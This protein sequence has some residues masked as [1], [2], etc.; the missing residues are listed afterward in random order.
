MQKTRKPLSPAR[1]VSRVIIW[2][3][4]AVVL[5]MRVVVL[6]P[7]FQWERRGASPSWHQRQPRFRRAPTVMHPPMSEVPKD[8]LRIQ[9]EIA[10]PDA[11]R[12]RR[13]FWDG[14]QGRRQERPEVRAT[15]REGGAVY[16]NVAVHLKGAAGSFRPF[17]DKPALTLSFAKYARGQRFHGYAKLSLNNSVQD[18]TYLCEAISRELFE[19]AGVPVPRV[20]FAT[21][22]INGVDKGLYV[23]AEGYNKDF[24][25]R[26]YRNVNGNLYDGG[27]CREVNPNLEVN[28]GDHPDDRS[29]LRRLLAAAS[30]PAAATRWNRLT[31]VLDTDRFITFLAM[32]V[33]LCH[34]DGYALNR[35]NYRLFHDLET[36]RLIFMPHGLDQMFDWPPG[37]F[38]PEGPILP[39]M[40]G[41]VAWAVMSTPQGGRQYL[42]RLGTLRTNVLQE[43]VVTQRV[44]ELA[45]RIRPTL[46]AYDPEAARRHDAAVASL[47]ERITR[48][49]RSVSEQLSA[50]REPMKF[51]AS[52]TA[53]LTHWTPHVSPPRAPLTLE[54]VEEHGRRL[55]H[56][57]AGNAGGT[58]SWRSRVNLEGGQYRFEGRA[59][60]SGGSRI[61]LRISG[62]RLPPQAVAGTD[63]VP[64]SYTLNV[65]GFM[66]EVE[67]IC[68]FSGTRGEAW[69][70]LESLRLVRQ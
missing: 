61:C 29:D 17:D 51:D 42:E 36:D 18:R 44:G 57:T 15:V 68:E 37:R 7:V 41:L 49:L 30:E 50:P 43:Q 40:N 26:Y 58:G 16:T 70:D 65:D 2:V 31:Q 48:R 56:I 34:W 9:I 25:R 59:K 69:F 20:D 52:G 28:S 39:T 38:P 6:P 66:T 3:A 13:Y 14:W 21:V 11:E 64:L 24:L 1:R 10:P 12:L 54:Q 23:L 19:A 62:A 8:L 63:W 35:N 53:P 55:L 47:C 33:L 22:L 32:E 67:L 60:T 27:F 45:Q 4:L 46:A 5:F